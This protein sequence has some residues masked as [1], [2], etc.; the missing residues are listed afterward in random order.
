MILIQTRTVFL[1]KK[2]NPLT[3]CRTRLSIYPRP[4]Y[5][6]PFP[7]LLQEDC[8]TPCALKN[9]ASLPTVST[10]AVTEPAGSL[11]ILFF[12]VFL[13]NHTEQLL[14]CDP[15]ESLWS[16]LECWD[17]FLTRDKARF[18]AGRISGRAVLLA[19]IYVAILYLWRRWLQGPCFRPLRLVFS[20]FVA[21]MLLGLASFSLIVL[22]WQT[23]EKIILLSSDPW[24]IRW[25][26]ETKIRRFIQDIIYINVCVYIYI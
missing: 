26:R 17:T 14:T 5:I 13:S 16:V 25:T 8:L 20:I 24:N 15:T 3:P 19:A 9:S 12:Y 6:P 10:A 11:R 23:N 2:N 18:F 4:R 7:T 22:E 1:R 21:L